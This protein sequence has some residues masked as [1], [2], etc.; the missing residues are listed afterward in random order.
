MKPGDVLADYVIN[1]VVA[2]D[3]PARLYAAIPPSRLG[4]Q[5]DR[6]AVKVLPGGDESSF[7]RFTRELKLYARVRHDALANVYDAGQHDIMFFYTTEWCGGGALESGGVDSREVAPQAIAQAARAA[8]ALHEAG[9]VHRDIRPGT[10]LRRGDGSAVLSD[11]GTAHVG[12]ATITS[13]APMASLG[14]VDPH[15]LLGEPAGRSTDIYSLGATLH[16]V[17]TGRY[18]Y[19]SLEGNDP[20]LALR[21]LLSQPP[22]IER[23]RLSAPLVDLI[24]AS[25]H[26]RLEARPPTA[27]L[28]AELLADTGGEHS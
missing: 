9:I 22:R 19:P 12:N 6:V 10:I 8:H 1:E 14:Y 7:R 21:H 2:H 27:E 24:A 4:L 13:M 23:E 15:L 3:G 25:T 11:L 18:L 20:L 5:A 26:R 28:F 17:M 16:R